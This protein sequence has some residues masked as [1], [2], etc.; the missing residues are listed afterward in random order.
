MNLSTCLHQFFDQY[1]PR[2]RGVSSHTV[3][4]YRA[5]LALF[6][7]FAAHALSI[8]MESLTL[9]HLSPKLILAFLDHLETE[10]FNI[11]RTRNLRLA[12]LKSLAKMIRLIYPEQRDIADRILY[13]PQKRAQKP[14][15]GFLSQGNYSGQ[16]QNVN[17]QQ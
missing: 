4:A 11:P 6:L 1:L 3:K 15:I 16:I 8:D 14:L 2:T 13:I 5:A 9:Q 7:P 12:A 10:R 17:T